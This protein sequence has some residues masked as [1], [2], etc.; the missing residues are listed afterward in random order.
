MSSGVDVAGQHE[1]V[2]HARHRHVRE[3]LAAAV[4]GGRHAH[5]AR[6]EAVLQVAAQDAVL[7]QHGA[8]GRRALVVDV[9]RAAAV[10]DRA[11]VDHGDRAARRRCW[12]MRPLKAETFLRLKSPSRPW[13]TASCS[14]TPGQPGPS[15]T[16][17]VPAGASTAL[18]VAQRL[19]GGGAHPAQI[20]VV[21]GEKGELD[22]AAAAG[23]ALLALAVL[24]GDAG[25]AEADERLDVADDDAGR[26]H[27]QDDLLLD[28]EAGQHVGDARIV[29]ARRDVDLVE[30][31]DLVVERRRRAAGAAA[32]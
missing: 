6:V 15:T 3:A 2:G 10:G 13:P 26:G 1:G 19:I 9:E 21:V 32:A 5:E 25:D 16:V 31:R 12:P 24:L 4:A 8:A 11:V 28:A 14:R 29:A 18:Q 20:A 30:Q 7:D 22:A 17:I 23:G 27:H